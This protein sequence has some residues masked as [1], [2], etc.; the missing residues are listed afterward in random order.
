MAR[1]HTL[2]RRTRTQS[3]LAA[4]AVGILCM[5][6]AFV[7]T[8]GAAGYKAE[9]LT[10]AD[11][12]D[13][14][15]YITLLRE[16]SGIYD[17]SASG[18]TIK[19]LE[20]I[21][22]SLRNNEGTMSATLPGGMR[23]ENDRICYIGPNLVNNYNRDTLEWDYIGGNNDAFAF[24]SDA[25]AGNDGAAGASFTVTWKKAGILRTTK[26]RLGLDSELPEGGIYVDIKVTSKL[27][28]TYDR[29]AVT[30]QSPKAVV[31]FT[32]RFDWGFFQ[33]GVIRMDQTFTFIDSETGKE[34]PLNG[35]ISIMA[36][37]LDVGEGFTVQGA[38]GSAVSGTAPVLNTH[39][40]AAVP[41]GV[42][43]AS[44]YSTIPGSY[45]Y[46]V[47]AGGHL[48]YVG[49]PDYVRA[50]KS[51]IAVQFMPDDGGNLVD[52]NYVDNKYDSIKY[53][54]LNGTMYPTDATEG[55]PW[56]DANT[57]AWRSASIEKNLA[58]SSSVTV[59]QYAV[60][61]EYN[62]I[63]AGTTNSA[64]PNLD[65]G[66]IASGTGPISNRYFNMAF[67]GTYGVQPQPPAK[68]VSN[69][70]PLPVGG[71]VSFT[72]SQQVNDWGSD[73]FA[74]YE[75][76]EIY[77][78]LD[79]NLSYVSGKVFYTAPG[80]TD[81]TDVTSAFGTVAFDQASRKVSAQFKG[82]Y[83]QASGVETNS[84]ATSAMVYK[85]GAYTLEIKAKVAS[86]AKAKLTNTG[87]STINGTTK[88][89]GEVPVLV[90]TAALDISKSVRFENAVGDEA[91]YSISVQNTKEGSVAR[92]V[93]VSDPVPSG[94]Q[95]LS[96]S[97][98]VSGIPASVTLESVKNNSAKSVEA[99][100]KA[101]SQSISNN[102]LEATIP[103]LPSGQKIT[104]T[105][106]VKCPPE[107]NGKEL[108]NTASA[109]LDNP[110]SDAEKTVIAKDGLW[111]NSAQLKLTKNAD[112]FQY[113]VGDTATY[114]IDVTNTG[115]E[116]TIAKNVVVTDT[117][118]PDRV[119]VNA[120]SATVTG[121]PATVAWPIDGNGVHKDES[122]NAAGAA[123]SQGN[124]FVVSI[125][126]LAS[127]QTA[128]ITYTATCTKASNGLETFN[129]AKAK[130][131][132]PLPG[133]GEIVSKDGIW[134]NNAQ[135]SITKTADK[136][137]YAVGET[138]SYTL[139]VENTEQNT[140]AQNV[141]IDDTTL[142]DY[143]TL[144]TSSIRVDG[145]PNPVSFNI[146]GK[147]EHAEESRTNKHTVTTS[148]N[149]FSVAIPYLPASNK[150]VVTYRAKA[151]EAANGKEVA[152]TARATLDNPLD[153]AKKTVE[154]KDNVWVNSVELDVEK[155]ADSFEYRVGDVVRY[156]LNV[157]NKAPAG[158]IAR[159]VKVTDSDLPDTVAIDKD[160][161]KVSGVVA[162]VAYPIDGN[163]EH[164]T[165]DR[166]SQAKVAQNGNGFTVLI[167]YLPAGKRA[168]VSY[169]AKATENANGGEHANS[170]TC[171][172]DNPLPGK[173]PA[174]K[175]DS[176]WVNN[177]QLSLAKAADA[178]EYGVG[179]VVTYTVALENK[180]PGTV[181]CDVHLADTTLPPYLQLDPESIVVSGM[182]DA[183][184]F[185]VDGGPR[186]TENRAVE[187][188]VT[189]SGNGF[190]FTANYLPAD[191]P[192][193]IQYQA[194]ALE[195]GNGKETVNTAT[196]S[197]S[198]P[199][200]PG[201][202]LEA[203]DTVW[204][205]SAK[206]DLVKRA[207]AFEYRVNDTVHYLVTI[208]NTAAA[209]TIAKDI[210]L[211]DDSLPET[212]VFNAESLQVEGVPD[213]VSHPIDG[214]G[215]HASEPR[216]GGYEAAT[217]GN[218]FALR[219]PYLPAGQTVSLHYTAK[220]TQ[221]SNGTE[222][223]NSAT[224]QPTNSLPGYES[225]TSQ[226]GVWTN[227]AVLT[228]D[229]DVERY[230][231]QV[232]D[233]VRY[234]VRY[235]NLAPYTVAQN[236]VM[237]D[238]TLPDGLVLQP[239]SIVVEGMPAQVAYYTDGEGTHAE[240][241]RNNPCEVVVDGN[242]FR[243]E[244][245]YLPTG[246]EVLV[247]YTAI[248][249][250]SINGDE[251][252]NTARVAASNMVDDTGAED[253]AL[254]W[255]NTPHL[256]VA[257][258]AR[259]QKTKYSQGDVVTYRIQIDNE[260]V[261]T[262]ARNMCIDD[263][264]DVE[265]MQLVR[266]SI[267]VFD[268]DG[269]LYDASTYRVVQNMFNANWELPTT[270][271]MVCN[272]GYH[273]IWEDKVERTAEQ[274]NPL[275]ETAEQRLYVE[276]QAVVTAK[277]LDGA[278]VRNVAS[279][280][281]DN[282]AK[283][284]DDETIEID[285]P[286]QEP[287]P[288]PVVDPEPEPTVD[289]APEPQTEPGPEPQPEPE[290][291]PR[292]DPQPDPE[293]ETDPQPDSDPDPADGQ[294]P[295]PDVALARLKVRFITEA[296]TLLDSYDKAIPVG[297][298][299]CTK[300]E[301]DGYEFVRV[302]DR[303]DPENGT[304]GEGETAEV[305]YIYKQLAPNDPTPQQEPEPGTDQHPNSDPTPSSDPESKG[306]SGSSQKPDGN[307]TPNPGGSGTSTTRTESGSGS[308]AQ[309]GKGSTTTSHTPSNTLAKTADYLSTHPFTTTALVSAIM[310][311]VAWRM[312]TNRRLQARR[313][314]R[315]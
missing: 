240:E 107:T 124:G 105:F 154:D 214:N 224:A 146:D 167:D 259:E 178:F 239:E 286:T 106:K 289:P 99:S 98:A 297:D 11:L 199:L 17:Q 193:S 237:E 75:S 7:A 157:E 111:V 304:V 116:G 192:I 226:D 209:G 76:F 194:T 103:Y 202:V 303:F 36:S 179:D 63:A 313:R 18:G 212:V 90:A 312:R 166:T 41:A 35:P 163:G 101:A 186:K 219:I 183:V 196:A 245:A 205:N 121:A 299:S 172:L 159:N 298:Y 258:Q 131:D 54:Q 125:P 128:R 42:V 243:V 21:P 47:D 162:G 12:Y 292:T 94:L 216:T 223:Y 225:S 246:A 285:Q 283:T 282:A 307:A 96:D 248:A 30:G 65:G 315:E 267:M 95:V 13:N 115:P 153:P 67:S 123:V 117:D 232:G 217:S 275:G 83:L 169:T 133:A 182:P 220:A 189:P 61:Y 181:A 269:N 273:G 100:N 308:T 2:R 87:F 144:D 27:V 33:F 265:G 270:L 126:Y 46:E 151:T 110:A 253:D 135:L 213:E 141:L 142:P 137:E 40:G 81:R 210:V 52:I 195:A 288:E 147:G 187:W 164:R 1:E 227:D 215:D 68:T 62:R 88:R 79:E 247:R 266:P 127:G 138:V 290:P 119:K 238:A 228:L 268:T 241:Q 234:T 284:A 305:V 10:S 82:T 168:T 257:K 274:L 218:G 58:G 112:K 222:T 230:E 281:A 78:T 264:F 301:F 260:A 23:A 44:R 104:Y 291:E 203:S 8:A 278:K 122:R 306:D 92:N 263:V 34:V 300:K 80:A 93:K 188:T 25:N 201:E 69:H 91:T 309:Q 20:A 235:L 198:N 287:K 145:V 158:T 261:G 272:E 148:A 118:M 155:Q 251:V 221:P 97:L 102:A 233:E 55:Y 140:I 59:R 14:G 64:N 109:T 134:V 53:F 26:G 191:Q 51:A 256:V 150:V 139:Q 165:E 4:A 174:T 73:I 57:Y 56:R 89:T 32:N 244:S 171:Q 262:F 39:I 49:A 113:Q 22:E 50:E 3:A 296:G 28:N 204:I 19:P 279:A 160:S 252:I 31:Q 48:G 190:S 84:S 229:K 161:V 86:D 197:C 254:I 149:G 72:V 136:F 208:T 294:E 207:D 200:V 295:L 6:M 66:L 173:E 60:G 15:Y 310:A 29:S 236:V 9:T 152:N 43:A 177:A 184:A 71:E 77:D 311:F 276:F 156:T 302:D 277:E 85:G 242:S 108:F 314:G 120:G 74:P 180:A 250:E 249:S 129:S 16:S 132:N 37:S 5:A 211:A 176:V 170:V 24:V 185:P 293:P 206:L 114:T 255:V 280:W 130:L 38:S 175:R 271:N 231:Y 143:L 70:E 45:L